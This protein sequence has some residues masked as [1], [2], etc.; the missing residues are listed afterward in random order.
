[1][2][3]DRLLFVSNAGILTGLDITTGEPLIQHRLGGNFAASPV[4]ANGLIYFFDQEGV[5][6]V[7]RPPVSGN[8][9]TEIEIIATNTLDEGL[10]ASPAVSGDALFLR[11]ST[12]LYCVAE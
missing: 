8:G 9:E 10:M 4:V 7:I 2:I 6:T 11:T 12:F 3:D 5:G 1:M